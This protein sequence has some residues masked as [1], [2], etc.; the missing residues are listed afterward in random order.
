MKNNERTSKL[1][2]LCYEG[3]ACRRKRQH[4]IYYQADTSALHGI[5]T[6]LEHNMNRDINDFATTTQVQVVV[7]RYFPV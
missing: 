7:N 4:Y 6:M 5:P 1:G 3:K 2:K